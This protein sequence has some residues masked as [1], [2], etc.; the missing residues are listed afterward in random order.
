M[1]NTIKREYKNK[2]V[3]VP[4]LFD[5][6]IN[7]VEVKGTAMITNDSNGKTISLCCGQFSMTIPFEPIEEFLK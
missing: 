1:S 2:S 6:G 7:H 5:N 3:L 4:M